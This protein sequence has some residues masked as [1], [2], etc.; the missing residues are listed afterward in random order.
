MKLIVIILLSCWSGAALGVGGEFFSTPTTNWP[1]KFSPEDCTKE[2]SLVGRYCGNPFH[3]RRHFYNRT[4]KKCVLFIP[5]KCGKYDVGNNFAKRKDCM[6]TCMKKS[7]C[8]NPKNGR[9]NG[10]V[11]GYTYDASDDFCYRTKYSSKT[12]FWPEKNRFT[13]EKACYDECAPEIVP[14]SWQSK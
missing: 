7:P 14:K 8:L 12:K 5:E 11:E 2:E 3:E 6:T 13:T 4:T 10:T 9:A 1:R